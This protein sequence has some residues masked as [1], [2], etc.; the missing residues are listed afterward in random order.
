M[1][2]SSVMFET[3]YQ[4]DNGTT[5]LFLKENNRN[6]TRRG[7]DSENSTA[8]GVIEELQDVSTRRD[9][10]TSISDIYISGNASHHVLSLNKSTTSEIKNE[11]ISTTTISDTAG[12]DEVR[13]NDEDADGLIEEYEEDDSI[14]NNNIPDDIQSQVD[15]R[16]LI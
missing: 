6:E 2:E 14:G 12:A 4:N 13:D 7:E 5:E 9:E 8:S 15:D 11:F 10:S 1:T 16:Y 3:T